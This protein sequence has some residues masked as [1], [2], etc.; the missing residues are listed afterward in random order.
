MDFSPRTF[1]WPA[2][3]LGIASIAFGVAPRRSSAAAAPLVHLPARAIASAFAAATPPP[4]P[5]PGRF[6]DAVDVSTFQRGNLH[7]HS[8]WSD[9][10]SHP[11]VVYAWYKAHGYNWLAITDHNTLTNP[12][13]FKLLE[14]KGKFVIIPGEEITMWGAGKQ[15]HVNALCHKTSI[16][17][18]KTDTQAEAMA[19]AIGRIHEQGGVALVNHPNWDWSWGFESIA[20]AKGAELIE[21]FSGHPFVHQDGDAAHESHEHLWD[22]ALSAGYDFTGVAVDDAHIF[23]PRAGPKAATPG[24]GWVEVFAPEPRRDLICEA[25]AKGR[26]YSSS[27]PKLKRIAVDGGAFTVWPASAAAVVEFIGKDGEVLQKGPAHRSDGA[28]YELV[29]GE[30]YLRARVT[31]PNGKRAWTAAYRVGPK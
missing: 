4:P 9:G 18:H 15:V 31:D 26:L 19:W 28:R 11:A 6:L 24:H 16:G 29:G 10:D 1:G 23:G 12:A 8:K 25:L 27:G 3:A 30:S 2:L 13:T 22:H 17:G 7:T 21:I 14:K 5:V 20:G